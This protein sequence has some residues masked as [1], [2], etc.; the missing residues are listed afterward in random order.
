MSKIKVMIVDDHDMVRMGLKTYLM[1][2]PGFEV[3]AEAG[4]AARFTRLGVNDVFA[5]GASAPYLFHT[6]GLSPAAIAKRFAA[7][8]AQN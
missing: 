4:I 2:D 1:Q 7:L 5:E 3:I 6:Y 8:A